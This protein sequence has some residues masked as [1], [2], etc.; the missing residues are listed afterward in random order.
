MLSATLL[1]NG[2]ESFK[3]TMLGQ[4]Q[5][6]SLTPAPAIYTLKTS[7]NIPDLP[8]E[9][10]HSILLFLPY[11]GGF[12]KD[13]YSVYSSNAP[14]FW[15]QRDRLHK[16]VIKKH[17][18]VRHARIEEKLRQLKEA[19]YK[20]EELLTWPQIDRLLPKKKYRTS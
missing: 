20:E 7:N 19:G 5:S 3:P 1:P 11:K 17:A 10:L 18:P 12:L 8:P 2:E 9:L 15:R 14:I 16:R 13:H 6:L 4:L